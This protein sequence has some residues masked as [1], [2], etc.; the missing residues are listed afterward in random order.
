MNDFKIGINLWSQGSSWSHLLDTALA[1]DRLGY[2]HLWTW[3]H[4][5]AIVGDPDQPIHEGWTTVTAWA[6]ATQRVRIGLMVGANTF[7][8][9]ALVAKIVTTLDHASGGRAIL[10]IGGAW[11]ELEH[12]EFGIDFGSS[13]GQ[14]LDWLDESVGAI[15]AL[16]S[17]ERVTSPE[18][19]HYAFDDLT[20]NPMPVQKRLPILIGGNGRTKTLRTLARYGDM[21]NAFGLPAEV[22]ELDGVLRR[23]CEEVGRDEREIERSINLWLVIR[24]SE[25]AARREWAAWME[26]NR[27]P[28]E[29]KL[30]PSRPVFGTPETIVARLL[31]YSDAGFKTVIVEMPAPYDRETLERL[32]REVRPMVAQKPV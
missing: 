20:I 13:V 5:K 19:G 23:H 7:R 31:E 10:G 28:V 8:N 26:L 21:W 3:D 2:E 25:A 6:M 11:F 22:R 17:G 16:L 4:V 14:R 9:P 32:A 18:G 12:R 30:E 15:R 27:T 29:K 24:D 1:V